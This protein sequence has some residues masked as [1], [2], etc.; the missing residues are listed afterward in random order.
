ML[1]ALVMSLVLLVNAG[2]VPTG[3]TECIKSWSDDD[4]EHVYVQEWRYDYKGN[5]IDETSY[6]ED[7]ADYGQELGTF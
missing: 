5:L 6:V 4:P 7:Y 1:L 2:V 3:H